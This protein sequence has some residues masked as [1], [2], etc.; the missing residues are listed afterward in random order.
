MTTLV[1]GATGHLGAN[2]VRALLE[3][4]ET[5]RA[6]IHRSRLGLDGLD[7][8]TV[9]GAI[10]DPESLRPAFEGVEV[11]YHLAAMISIVGD[12]DG[13]VHRTNVVG[14]RTVALVAREAGVRRMVHCSSVDAFDRRGARD[15]DERKPRVTADTDNVSA[16]DLSKAQ[17]EAAVREQVD[18]GLDAVIVH[19]SGVIGPHD[20]RPSRIGKALLSMARGRLPAVTAGGYDWVDVRDVATSMI[21]AA[22]RG[23]TGQSY[24]LTNRY[25][26][27]N[28]LGDHIGAITGKMKPFLT[29]PM[30]LAKAV[31]PLGETVAR[32]LDAEPLFTEESLAVLD[33]EARFDHGLA[34]EELGHEPRDLG[35]TLADTLRWFSEHGKL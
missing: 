6:L 30:S 22:E 13:R 24:L 33:T 21:A 8:E 3:R 19:P 23:R 29:V 5:V 9:E 15:I 4:G 26:T 11:V 12:P 32:W 20:Y 1:T 2:L 16:Y 10:D 31:A 14:A 17:G 28:E 25:A 34:R 27:L 18:A 35:T 7:V